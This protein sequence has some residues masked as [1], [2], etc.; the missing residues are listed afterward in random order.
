MYARK[1]TQHSTPHGVPRDRQPDAREGR[2]GRDARASHQ[3]PVSPAC[4][5]KGDGVGVMRSE[6]GKHSLRRTKA[7][8]IYRD[9][10]TFAPSKSCGHS[11]NENTECY[12]GN[13]G[14]D[15]LGPRMPRSVGPRS[16][17]EPNT[18]AWEKVV[19]RVIGRECRGPN[20]PFAR[21]P[22]S[23]RQRASLQGIDFTEIGSS[24][25][26]SSRC[27]PHEKPRLRVVAHFLNT[28]G[29]LK[30]WCDMEHL[31]HRARRTS[32]EFA[33]CP[34]DEHVICDRQPCLRKR[35]AKNQITRCVLRTYPSA[36][37]PV[38]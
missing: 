20:W 37:M 10:A 30:Q 6:Y 3:S 19:V 1:C 13:D 4:R 21:V 2:E 27:S 32:L 22:G 29:Y 23:S 12:L 36:L 38:G 7:A 18:G 11:K 35:I 9:T 5:R 31:P 8:I 28:T 25:H 34:D 17:G 24:H 16:S 15:A 33:V 26:N 14:E